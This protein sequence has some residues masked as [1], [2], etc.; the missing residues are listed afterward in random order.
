MLTRTRLSFVRSASRQLERR[1]FYNYGLQ[2]TKGKVASRT[3]IQRP[4]GSQA[5][6]IALSL[7]LAV[8]IAVN[9][10]PNILL[11]SQPLVNNDFREDPAT[12][13]KFPERLR[14]PSRPQLPTCQLLGVGVRKVSILGI[15][16]YSVA[17]YADLDRPGLKIPF[18]SSFEEQVNYLIGNTTCILRII[19]TR[20]TS[21]THLRDGFMR[22]LQTRESK[23]R[24][25]GTLLAKDDHA[26]H[27][28]LLKFKALF[29]NVTLQKHTS[30]DVVL[31]LPAD[32]SKTRRLMIWDLGFVE[33]DWVA[34]EFFKAYFTN[35]G[36]SPPL[37]QETRKYLEG[38]A[39]AGDA[40]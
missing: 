18:H 21:Y 29:P 27:S 30:I 13:I 25:E 23:C 16:V 24:A 4:V 34:T 6:G 1:S 17:F 9:L 11:D 40:L 39:T 14:I 33:N 15:K 28:A 31:S 26:L 7:A 22:A 38:C 35:E 10:N 19:P 8:G 37:K 3:P 32:I 12:A 36:V 5:G 2:L 20:S